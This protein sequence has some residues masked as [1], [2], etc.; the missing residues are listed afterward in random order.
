MT[1]VGTVLW[2]AIAVAYVVA[3]VVVGGLCSYVADE[4]GRSAWSWFFLGFL[5]GIFALIAIAGT[6]SVGEKSPL[7]GRNAK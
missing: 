7:G 5:C 2:I 3:A 4:K 1:E 6:P